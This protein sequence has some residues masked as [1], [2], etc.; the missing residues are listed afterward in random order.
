MTA[1]V[2][3]RR[4]LTDEIRD[5]IVQDL[6]LSGEFSAGERLPT[7]AQLCHRYNASRVTIRA[8]LRSL[9]EAGLIAI[10]QGRGSTVL[11]RPHAIASGL[12]RLQSFESFAAATGAAVSSEQLEILERALDETE[13]ERLERAPGDQTM[14]IRRVKVYGSDKVS[15]IDDYVPE[16]VLPFQLLRDEFNGSVLDVLLSHPELEVEYSDCDIKVIGLPDHVAARLDVDTGVPSL[17]LDE[18]TRT[19]TGQVV[20]WSRAWLLPDYFNINVRRRRQFM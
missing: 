6:L 13:A 7:E 17:L 9:Q 14:I 4:R 3:P 15:W 19:R 11:P 5:S 12:D 16:D 18:L 1:A 8:A 10:R 2:R 20:N